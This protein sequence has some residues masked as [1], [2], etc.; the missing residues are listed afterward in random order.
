MGKNVQSVYADNGRDLDT[1]S[2]GSGDSV[3][4]GIENQA[5]FKNYKGNN[6]VQLIPH[7]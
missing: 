1:S 5:E 6:K 7:E 3:L 2:V 4:I